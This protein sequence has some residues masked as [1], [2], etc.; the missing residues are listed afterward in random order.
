M[1]RMAAN[2][3][4]WGEW[5]WVGGLTSV[6]PFNSSRSS[7][8]RA[9]GSHA[10]G[11]VWRLSTDLVGDKR[12]EQWLREDP[13]RLLPPTNR[14][15][16]P[17]MKK[18]ID[19]GLGRTRSRACEVIEKGEEGESASCAH[20]CVASSA[21]RARHPGERIKVS[22]A[23]RHLGREKDSRGRGVSPR[24]KGTCHLGRKNVE[25]LS[26][27]GTLRRWHWDAICGDRQLRSRL[28]GDGC[29]RWWGEAGRW[30]RDSPSVESVD[31]EPV[32]RSWAS[33]SPS[34]ESATRTQM[35]IWGESRDCGDP[36][37]DSPSMESAARTRIERMG[38]GE[39]RDWGDSGER[40]KTGACAALARRGGGEISGVGERAEPCWGCGRPPYHLKE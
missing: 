28:K 11:D 8:S 25:L 12:K 38:R 40:A 39:S 34:M 36:A 33:D 4:I 24:G 30:Q 3:W 15:Y 26:S 35:G 2:R 10:H 27:L 32:R 6:H 31:R 22:P 23:R 37:D 20:V 14:S 1:K 17:R 7:P 21:R 5:G 16:T 29:R 19:L 13:T 9:T 18:Q